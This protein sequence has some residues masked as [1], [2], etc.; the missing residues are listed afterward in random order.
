MPLRSPR[1]APSRADTEASSIEVVHL[2]GGLACARALD[3]LLNRLLDL[4]PIA[5]V[6]GHKVCLEV[7]CDVVQLRPAVLVVHE[8][9]S[10]TDTS[11][12][13]G[14]T[15]AVQVCLRVRVKAISHGGN[16]LD[17]VSMVLSTER[18]FPLT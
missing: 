14:T 9:E 10:D 13:S 6:D 8:C 4:I 2:L 3:D 11:K 7:R 18:G 1:C 15:N 16:V 17:R 12:S 5:C